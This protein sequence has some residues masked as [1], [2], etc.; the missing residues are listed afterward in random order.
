MV[1]VR[2]RLVRYP[3]DLTCYER[4]EPLLTCMIVDDRGLVL[5]LIGWRRNDRPKALIGI[6]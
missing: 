3:N 5:I 6:I 2:V 1:R 4:E